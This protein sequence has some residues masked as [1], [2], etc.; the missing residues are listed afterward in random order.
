MELVRLYLLILDIR[1]TELL[2][3]LILEMNVLAA[4][5]LISNIITSKIIAQY[6][7]RIMDGKRF[8]Y[9]PVGLLCN[10]SQRSYD[11]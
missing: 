10:I 1:L 4:T 2:C 9:H 6:F 11:D 8:N 5:K 3:I 7:Q